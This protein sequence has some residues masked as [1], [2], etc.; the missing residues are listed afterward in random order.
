MTAMFID[1]DS[2]ITE[3]STFTSSS[4]S[5]TQSFQFTFLSPISQPSSTSE[6]TLV[7][8]IDSPYSPLMISLPQ[9]SLSPSSTLREKIA[10]NHVNGHTLGCTSTTWSLL[11]YKPTP[12]ATTLPRQ[13]IVDNYLGNAKKTRKNVSSLLFHLH[14]TFFS[15]YSQFH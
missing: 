5:S 4:S 1:N 13:R 6:A 15:P 10:Y 12:P 8:S 11:L 9:L 2:I 3:T 14:N 7:P